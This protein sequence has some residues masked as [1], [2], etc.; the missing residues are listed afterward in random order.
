M[1]LGEDSFFK[2]SPNQ[3]G[4]KKKANTYPNLLLINDQHLYGRKYKIFIDLKANES[5]Y[6]KKKIFSSTRR[7]AACKLG[8]S[9]ESTNFEDIENTAESLD[10]KSDKK[11]MVSNGSKNYA[12]DY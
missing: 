4:F 7:L 1:Q 2:T 12:T 8:I 6:L 11:S 5:G 9:F 10:D 3:S